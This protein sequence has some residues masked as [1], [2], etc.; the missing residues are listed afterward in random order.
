MTVLHN[1]RRLHTVS[2]NHLTL[3]K[4]RMMTVLRRMPVEGD[5]LGTTSDDQAV[6][7]LSERS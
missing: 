1:G 6:P 2:G 7:P 4:G 3:S 5:A